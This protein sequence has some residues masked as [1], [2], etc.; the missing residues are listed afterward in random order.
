MVSASAPVDAAANSKKE[1]PLA[2][3]HPLPAAGLISPAAMN[4][5]NNLSCHTKDLLVLNQVDAERLTQTIHK[6]EDLGGCAVHIF[7]PRYLIGDFPSAIQTLLTQEGLLN[8][9]YSVGSEQA[10]REDAELPS[11]LKAIWLQ[12]N[13]NPL[14]SSST[15]P[16]EINGSPLIGDVRIL[17]EGRPELTLQEAQQITPGNYQTSEFMAGKIAVG[18]IFPESDGSLDLNYETWSSDRM[19]RVV[20]KIQAALNWWAK[21]NPNGHLSFIYDIHRQTPT[22]YEPIIHRSDQDYLWINDTFTKLGYSNTSMR[23]NAFNYLNAIRAQYH[24]DW[25]VVAFVVDSLKDGD[26]E[27]SDGYFA[28]T[29]VNPGLIVMTYDNDG[30]TINNLDSVFAHEFAHDFG[31]AD[32]Y[33]QPGYACCWGGLSY[34][35]A[36]Y[37]YSYLYVPNS[38]CEAGCDHDNNGIC[39]G[40]DSTPNS[41]CQN[42]P[43]CVQVQCLMKDGSI[44]AGIDEPS[45]QQVG[46]RDSDGDGILDPLDIAVDLSINQFPPETTPS[47]VVV[48]SGQASEQ[49][50]PTPNPKKSSVTINFIQAIQVQLDNSTD[51]VTLPADDGNYDEPQESFSYTTPSLLYGSHTVKIRASD[52]FGNFSQ[53]YQYTF[54]V[55]PDPA[56]FNFYLPVILTSPSLLTSYLIHLIGR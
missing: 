7:P 10:V 51:W 34:D 56:P 40:N 2:V 32:E 29:Y 53:L 3:D 4:R 18:I 16:S 15:R 39:D 27:F 31:A 5:A 14:V 12:L 19:D 9:Y 1:N 43:S 35:E 45:K 52:R 50:Y 20:S 28:Y 30:W 48:F 54:T 44:S 13:G 23:T 21:T 38:N 24:T 11:W 17:P 22:K 25:A 41:N 47:T 26:G 46:I 8:E 37:N 49:P 55:M 36:G 6:I 42:C 33:C